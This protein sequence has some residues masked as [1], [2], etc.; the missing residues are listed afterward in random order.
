MATSGRSVIG[1]TCEILDEPA[2]FVDA[3][4]AAGA[5]ERPGYTPPALTAPPEIAFAGVIFTYA[6]RDAPALD[7]AD[8]VLATGESVALV[9]AS[10]AG[11]STVANL[12]LRFIEPDRGRIEVDGGALALVSRTS[13][14]ASLAWVP[15]RPHLFEGSVADNIRLAR[16]DA[17]DAA[18]RAA[19]AAANADG[20]IGQLR[21]GYD[22]AVGEGGARL[23]GGQRQ[24]IAIA[25]AYLR[26]APL[27][28]LDEATSHQDE[29]SEVAIADALERLMVGR[30][31]LLIAHRLRLAQRAE[32]VVVLDR[33]RAVEAGPPAALLEQGGAYRRLL[34]D[35][36]RPEAGA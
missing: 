6:G 25:R 11:K 15:Q 4:D 35:H 8:L 23:S 3:P 26:D 21:D 27:L 5:A 30:T 14:R 28:L 1:L 33:G 34:E 2:P 9:G 31:V 13:W 12:L 19:A 7:G 36:D 10:G 32:R 24:R 16:P 17:D 29:E 22:T 18:V 20:F